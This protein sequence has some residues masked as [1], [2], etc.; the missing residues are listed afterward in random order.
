SMMPKDSIGVIV[1]VNGAHNRPL[2]NT[3]SYNIYDRLLD[4]EQTDFNG[5]RLKERLENK[6]VSKEARAKAGSDKIADTKP[7]HPLGDYKG[8]YEDPAY[9][10]LNITQEGDQLQ[11]D[12]HNIVLP[13]EHYHYER[14][15]TPDDQIYG[16]YSVNFSTNPQGDIYKAVISMDE[17][18]VD[19]I[20]K[21]DESLS[22][23]TI[24]TKYVGK[25]ELAGNILE[26]VLKNEKTLVT[27]LPG[28]PEYTLEPYKPHFFTM[29]EFSDI[30]MEFTIDGDVAKTLKLV[31]PNGTYEYMRKTD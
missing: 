16:K 14:F 15:D 3:I 25:Y 31:V 28:Q 19:F 29:K 2:I 26:I 27:K 10:L 7:S 1:F 20:K 9:G 6:K 18:E 17:S 13:L 12:F 4:L 5:R 22:D 24:L 8:Q 11:F 23:P 21:P 30:T